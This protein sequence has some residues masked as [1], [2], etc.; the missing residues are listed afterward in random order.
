MELTKAETDFRMQQATELGNT[1]GA[2]SDLVGKQTAAGKALGVA[3]ALINTYIGV[4]EILRQKSVIPSPGDYIAKAV[5]VAATLATGFK[6]VKAITSVKVPGGGGGN[7]PSGVTAG[8]GASP[9][10]N[11][12]GNSGVNALAQT[13]GTQK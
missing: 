4:T 8:G 1:L 13:I 3:Q 12:V 2:L 10:F 9:S 6:A 11:V 5:N 7:A